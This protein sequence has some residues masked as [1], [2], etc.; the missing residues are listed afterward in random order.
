VAQ[1]LILLKTGCPQ[2]GQSPF[3]SIENSSTSPPHRGQ[4]LI[5]IAG[6]ALPNEPGH[7]NGLTMR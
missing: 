2:D 5:F 6:V 4:I 1:E 7:L 3:L